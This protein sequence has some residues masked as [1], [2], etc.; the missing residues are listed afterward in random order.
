[1]HNMLAQTPTTMHKNKSA[2]C[3]IVARF[4]TLLTLGVMLAAFDSIQAQ[5]C[6]PSPAGLVGWWPGDGDG[7]DLAATNTV[8]LSGGAAFAPGWAGQAFSFGGG[9]DLVTCSTAGRLASIQNTFTVEFWARPTL[10]RL[11]TTEQGTGVNGIGGQRYAVAPEWGG[12][13]QAGMGVSVGTNG[14]SVFEHGNGYLPSVLVYNATLSGW[15]HI[16]VVYTNRIPAL[17]VNG[18]LARTGLAGARSVVYPSIMFGGVAGQPGYGTYA[19]L[20]DEV[21]IY[22]RALAVDE[23]AAIYQAGSAGKCGKLRISIGLVLDVSHRP[24]AGI[25]VAGLAGHTYGIQSTA[26]LASSN[27]W[28]GLTNL[29]LTAPTQTWY[30]PQTASQTQRFYRGVRGP[31]PVP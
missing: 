19:G 12:S 22:N 7:S 26:G 23:I 15:V 14:I 25:A 6:A 1:M 2:L 28:V 3:I 24:H 16:A 17:Y 4:A 20:L 10:A 27:I 11:Q 31:I 30:D 9:S 18:V 29:T 5:N 13:S 8:A 21:A